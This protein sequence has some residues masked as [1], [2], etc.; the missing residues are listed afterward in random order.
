MKEEHLSIINISVT[1]PTQGRWRS[2][3]YVN[4][5][6]LVNYFFMEWVGRL[7]K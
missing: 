4:A 7:Y 5:I 1:L 3:N 6:R 2:N